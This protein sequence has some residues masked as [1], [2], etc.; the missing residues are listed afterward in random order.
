M[1]KRTHPRRV[2]RFGALVAPR[3]SWRSVVL[4]SFALLLLIGL[5][6]PT[7]YVVEGAGP[8]LETTSTIDSKPVVSVTDVKTYPTDSSYYLTTVTAWGE[9][10]NGVTGA[11]ALMALARPDRQLIP[12]ALMYPPQTTAQELD[13]RNAALMTS[14]QD[15]AA[16]VGFELAGYQPSMVLRVASTSAD[17][18]ASGKLRVGDTITG[19]RRAGMG[20]EGANTA[21]NA[22]GAGEPG[23]E[24]VDIESFTSL[25][26]YLSSVPPGTAIE[27]RIERDGRREVVQFPT[28]PYPADSTGWVHPGSLLGVGV[29]VTDVQLPGAVQYAVEGIGGPSAGNIFALTV[30]DELTPGSLA[31]DAKIAGT[32]E[33]E[34]DGD[35]TPIGGIIHK[36]NGARRQGATDFLAPAENCSETQG[37]VPDGMNVWAVRSVSESITAAEAIG[38]GDTASLTPCSAF[39]ENK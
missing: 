35:V 13:E 3:I 20:A 39:F 29:A 21:N 26:R 11:Q 14:S 7:N 1:L 6:A 38:A 37:H 32:G 22:A 12:L 19:I 34:F 5:L 24:F 16:V 31:A 15:A 10:G 27:V 30:Y 23:E 36:L 9:P 2:A 25:S 17:Y 8:A 4:Y 18:L 28:S 33:V